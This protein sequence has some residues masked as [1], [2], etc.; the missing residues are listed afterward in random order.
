MDTSL[1]VDHSVQ[2]AACALCQKAFS[3]SSEANNDFGNSVCGDCKFLLL[4]DIGIPGQD[5]YR[6]RRGRFRYSSSESIENILSQQFPHMINTA[7]QNQSTMSGLEDQPV[8]GDAASWILQRTSSRTTPS[9]SRRWRRVISDTESDGLDNPDSLY[10][11][12]E[13]HVSLG[14][15]RFSHGESDSSF[16]FSAYGGD[17]DASVD[18]HSFMD[19]EMF[20][21]P[22]V[23]SDDSDTDIDPM[24]AGVSQ[25]DSDDLEEED[26][27]EEDEE[28]DE[29]RGWEVAEAEE[30]EARSRLPN[31]LMSSSRERNDPNN[32]R[33]WLHSPESEGLIRRRITDGWQTYTNNILTNLEEP[34]LPHYH[35]A[36]YGDY[37]DARGFENL[38]ENLAQNDSSRRGSPPASVS[39]LNSLPLI[40]ISEEHEKHDGLTCAICKDVITLGTEVNQLPCLHLYHPSC[41]L[42]WLSNRNSCPLCRYELPTDDKEYEESKRNTD[43]RMEINEFQQRNVTD[44]SSSNVSDEAEAYEE[45][46]FSQD[47]SEQRERLD[48]DPV[49]SSSD[50]RG[51]RG[52]FLLAAAPI[53]SLV[54]FVIVLWLG[55]PL[56]VR[57]G[58]PGHCNLPVQNQH[59]IHV[60]ASS[61]R[62]N[63]RRWW[64]LF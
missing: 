14:R 13:S 45:H 53:V 64:S 32:W 52:W 60:S 43:G 2:T 10:G 18:G 37:L 62:D 57:R 3:P 20:I 5:S 11:D 24:R 1:A 42:P 21:L 36:T 9:G 56:T 31:L 50:V 34:E 28:E 22:D 17:S 33:Q 25:W 44:D 51:G 39:F 23:G 59:Q 61:Q 27:E 47:R 49:I 41:I 35:G 16:S 38:L 15:Y 54:G 40:T 26:E 7:R 30:D 58:R 6:R 29:E 4:E 63:R 12:S 46:G 48:A 55:N 19:T 8:D